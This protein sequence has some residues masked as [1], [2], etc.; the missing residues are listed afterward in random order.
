MRLS[1][2]G[3]F[4][5]SLLIL[6]SRELSVSPRAPVTAPNNFFS[7]RSN[8]TFTR[9]SN[10]SSIT[11]ILG[12]AVASNAGGTTTEEEGRGGEAEEAAA[13]TAS[14]VGQKD[15]DDADDEDDEEEE[16]EEEEEERCSMAVGV[17]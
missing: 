6:P 13:A 1:L 3:S 15:D 5:A 11:E 2:V 8:R 7:S 16:E 10:A 12:K 17:G 4:F 9:F 14:G